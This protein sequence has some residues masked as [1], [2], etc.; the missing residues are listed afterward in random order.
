M[1]KEEGLT[2]QEKEEKADLEEKRKA[3]GDPKMIGQISDSERTR[4]SALLAKEGEGG[5]ATAAT[6]AAGKK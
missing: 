1:G 2:E 5:K 6:T 4:L 3:A